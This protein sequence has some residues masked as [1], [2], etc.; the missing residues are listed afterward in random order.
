MGSLHKRQVASGIERIV[1]L[2]KQTNKQK[3]FRKPTRESLPHGQEDKVHGKHCLYPVEN[4][5][6]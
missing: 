2:N 5:A 6:L 3:S 1:S 4:P